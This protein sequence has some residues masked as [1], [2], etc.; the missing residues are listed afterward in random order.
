MV[1]EPDPT[2]LTRR[3][4]ETRAEDSASADVT[5]PAAASAD[6]ETTLELSLD[7]EATLAL[8]RSAEAKTV[9][10]PDAT[11]M[12]DTGQASGPIT[13]QDDAA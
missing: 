11:P 5:R 7:G 10:K 4:G 6:A 8:S 1:D 9:P 12:P 13:A 3:R 2:L